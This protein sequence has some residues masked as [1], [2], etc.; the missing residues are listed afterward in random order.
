MNSP[1][2]PCITIAIMAHPKRKEYAAALF[3]QLKQY[4]FDEVTL[5]FDS[6]NCEWTTGVEA[7]TQGIIFGSDWHVVIQDDA[8]LPADFYS[9]IKNAIAN[10]PDRTLISLYTGTVRPFRSR[11]EAAVNNA[12][13]VSWLRSNTLY[14]GVGIIIPTQHIGPMLEFVAD[15]KDVPYD[16]RIG[17]F[18]QR[19]RLPVYYTNP[20][21]VNHNDD[22]GSLIKNDYAAEKRVA[23]RFVSGPLNWNSKYIQI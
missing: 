4:P 22:I 16:A 1:A 11:V 15:R 23:H 12:K 2:D 19:N 6:D 14:W 13:N 8:I 20:S 17:V 10:V 3:E 9:H 7:L 21:L 5:V 18:Y